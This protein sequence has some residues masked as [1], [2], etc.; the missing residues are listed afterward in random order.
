MTIE[1]R[2]TGAADETIAQTIECQAPATI[3]DGDLLRLKA[4]CVNDINISVNEA[5]WDQV[6]HIKSTVG[7]DNAM[8]VFEK[9]ASSESGN[10]TVDIDG[11][12]NRQIFVQ[13]TAFSGVDETT[14]MDAAATTTIDIQSANLDGPAIVTVTDKAW[15]ESFVFARAGGLG[16]PTVPTGYTFNGTFSATNAWF[17]SATKADI[18]PAG[19]EDPGA[20]V[21]GAS[22][23]GGAITIALRPPATVGNFMP[24]S[25]ST[26]M[27]RV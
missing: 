20:F 6:A 18:S 8:A 5:G 14:P 12:I 15:V 11:G 27:V 16:V 4:A 10:Y 26:V 7:L 25:H 9:I 13:C 21:F 22:V 24:A 3:V 1:I 19:S 23:D 17:G 2:S